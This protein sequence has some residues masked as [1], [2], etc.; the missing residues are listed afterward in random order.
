MFNYA[1]I[2]LYGYANLVSLQTDLNL[3]ALA[4]LCIRSRRKI[5]Q[6]FTQSLHDLSRCILFVILL[7][8]MA[9]PLLLLALLI[10]QEE[11]DNF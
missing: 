3:I 5:I 4:F 2:L 10:D 8:I 7:S 6:K 9:L 1:L 11:P